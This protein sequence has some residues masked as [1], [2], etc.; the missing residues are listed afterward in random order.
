M[1][2]RLT[3]FFITVF[4]VTMNVLLWR[5]EYGSHGGEI[6]V[7]VELVWRKIL[8]APDASSLNVFQDGKRTGFCEFSTGVET[9]MAQLDENSPP[10]EGVAARAGYKIRL[11]GNLSLGELANR[12]RFNGQLQ[13][14]PASGWRELDLKISSRTAAVEIHS[15]ATNQN[16]R[17]K[18]TGDD[19]TIERDL[20]F[21]D[22]QN[23]GALLRAFGGNFG[24]DFP[25]GFDLPAVPQNSALL[26][27]T[28]R[29]E[30]HRER[31]KIGGEPVSV[32]RLETQ[33]LQNKIVIYVSTLGEILRVDLPGGITAA[34]D[35]WGKS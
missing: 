10:P 32:Y 13:F 34:P 22:L 29:W 20:A 21:A 8:T 18:I 35:A 9:E 23:P 6:S 3:F 33:V 31:M 15:L 16:V 11:D 7:P 2:P 14:S 5:A 25:G 27:Q 30:A 19:A 26:A 4:W 1:I 12:V 28:I 24:G 17:L